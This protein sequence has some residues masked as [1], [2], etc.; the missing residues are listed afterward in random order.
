MKK[1]RWNF[2]P[3]Q[4]AFLSVIQIMNGGI[5]IDVISELAPLRPAQFLYL[6][7]KS[8]ELGIV[9]KS[10]KDVFRLI[11]PLPPVVSK[12][13]EEINTPTRM[14][15]LL[16]RLLAADMAGKIPPPVIDEL[17]QITGH[18]YDIALQERVLALDAIQNDQPKYAARHLEKALSY[19]KNFEQQAEYNVLFVASAL[20]YSNLS[21][22]LGRNI[23]ALPSLLK[24]AQILAVR[25]GDRRSL[26][27]ITLHR[28]RLYYFSDALVDAIDA[29]AN[30]LKTV[31]DLGDGDIKA[32]SAEFRGLYYYLQ[33]YYKK[34]VEEYD[35][36]IQSTVISEDHYIQDFSPIHL[37]YALGNLGQFHRAV[38]IL[39]SHF[40]RM[41]Q[42]A[43]CAFADQSQAILGL[44]LLM[45][46][47]RQE[48]TKH[49]YHALEEA[50]EHNNMLVLYITHLA[51]AYYHYLEGHL[52]IAHETLL[53]TVVKMTDAG[54]IV[55]YYPFQCFIEMIF[56]FHQH[57]FEDLPGFAFLKEVDK[58]LNGPNIHLRGV[59]L[60]IRAQEYLANGL[61]TSLIEADLENS[62]K[63]LELA[64]D[65]IELAKTQAEITRLKLR[66]NDTE[67][68]REL[69]VKIWKGLPEPKKVFFP[70]NL[71]FLLQDIKET[72]SYRQSI[73]NI[74]EH[75]FRTMLYFVP[76]TNLNALL[77]R[78]FFDTTRL[79]Q[80]ERAGLFLSQGKE[81]TLRLSLNLTKEDLL[82]PDFRG[83]TMLISQ[84]FQEKRMILTST[85]NIAPHPMGKMTVLCIPY[86]SIGHI[87]GVLYYD[88]IYLENSFHFLD[89]SA[90]MRLARNIS[91]LLEWIH[92]CDRDIKESKKSDEV[93][94]P[95]FAEEPNNENMPTG[96]LAAMKIFTQAD[97]VA[98]TDA[99]VLI[100][101]ET[102]VGKELL[103]RR[104]HQMSNRCSGPFVVVDIASIPETLVE[105][106][107][108]GHE[109]GAFTG[110]DR[111]KKGRIEVANQGTLFIDELGEI[112]KS[113][114]VK[115]LR[116]LQDKTFMRIGGTRSLTSDF[117]LLAATNKDLQQ[118][119][120]KGN[121]RQDLF[122][123]VNVVTLHI[124]S[125]KERKEDIIPLIRHF[126]H[127]FAKQYNRPNIRLSP[128]DEAMLLSYPWLG[129]IRELK[130]VVERAVLLSTEEQT[131][132]ILP[133]ITTN[134]SLVG[135]VEDLPDM[136]EIQRRYIHHVLQ[137]TQGKISGAGGAAELLRMNRST[138]M[139][140]MKKLGMH[141]ETISLRLIP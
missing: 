49:L 128:R 77:E 61:E 2:S 132:F 104:I 26:A 91:F 127:I 27:L 73:E 140:R 30:G 137:R 124:P 58:I 81:L 8:M 87:Q 24:Q 130:N 54:F 11:N 113:T 18:E 56:A 82:L 45:M 40:H 31:E 37:G 106:E 80:A 66:A 129:N 135:F 38:G 47:K 4:W 95:L 100:L 5:T 50:K 139:A 84:A 15:A 71:R 10:G 13:L 86:E 42:R 34:A 3:E 134:P 99:P 22:R 101:G 43:E 29:M 39:D 7:N 117:R 119:I 105:S 53:Q 55:K 33:G 85:E 51:L 120:S 6:L 17:R 126:L 12:K 108:F 76:S 64:G 28:G 93:E 92:E 89:E 70:D 20:D 83:N 136:D 98:A 21:V 67:K 23:K 32:R 102:G 107:L 74:I 14:S 69:A 138:L 16:D 35:L 72:G 116:V 57:S 121:F 112:P 118:E 131:A 125:L 62:E 79:L 123:R 63:C 44:V 94:K 97:R 103:A 122:Y 52:D 133:K 60:R 96:N 1:P 109:K 114:Q 19:A 75:L 41:K 111:Q 141:S 78:L 90:L 59:A 46:G 25:L 110:A 36:A 115:L 9:K 68:A 88:S 48:A 65:P